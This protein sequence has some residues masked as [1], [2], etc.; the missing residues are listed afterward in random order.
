MFVDYYNSNVNYESVVQLPVLIMY[1][2][3]I[4]ILGPILQAVFPL[5]IQISFE[6]LFRCN[7]IP[8]YPSSTNF[9]MGYD[10][11]TNM[12][13]AKLCRDQVT[14]VWINQIE[15]F[16][17]FALYLKNLWYN[18]PLDVSYTIGLCA[19]GQRKF[20][21]WNPD[22]IFMVGVVCNYRHFG[23]WLKWLKLLLTTF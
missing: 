20:I 3:V 21:L 17:L 1:G 23:R 14:I 19:A 18:C 15:I 13:C 11:T 4:W 10:N 8:N 7:F 6:K 5:T 22:G 9:C 12:A 2:A 16:I